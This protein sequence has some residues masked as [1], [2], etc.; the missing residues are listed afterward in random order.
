MSARLL[1][2]IIA[3]G[4]ENREV[5]GVAKIPGEH[6]YQDLIAVGGTGEH[7]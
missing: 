6:G 7:P 4:K 2:E 1:G 5:Y 3:V